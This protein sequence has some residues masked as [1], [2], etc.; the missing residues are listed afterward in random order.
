[1]TE[2]GRPG[3]GVWPGWP[4]GSSAPPCGWGMSARPA[5]GPPFFFGARFLPRS[6]V[7]PPIRMGTISVREVPAAA[8]LVAVGLHAAAVAKLAVCG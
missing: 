5:F 8:A 1:M 6:A 4:P 2:G 3:P 7:A